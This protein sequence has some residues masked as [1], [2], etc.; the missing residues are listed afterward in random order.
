MDSQI[1]TETA[2]T[3]TNAN[4]SFAPFEDLRKRNERRARIAQLLA[5]QRERRRLAIERVSRLQREH[6]RRGG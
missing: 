4:G 3:D 2:D 1:D 5:A 6:R